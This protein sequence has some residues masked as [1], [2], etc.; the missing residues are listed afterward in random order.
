[1]DPTASFV[2]QALNT[3]LSQPEHQETTIGNFFAPDYRQTVNGISLNY[4]DFVSHLAILKQLTRSMTVKVLTIASQENRV[5]THHQ[6]TA[7]K[8]G[9]GK[10]VSEVFACFTVREGRIVE[11]Q[12][13]TRLISGAT[14]DNELGSVH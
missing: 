3:V 8:T 2:M 10:S 11:C 7:C 12:E 9:G 13:L 14:E 5:L 4:R 6:V 1:M